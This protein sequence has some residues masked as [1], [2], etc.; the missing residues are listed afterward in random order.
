[1]IKLKNEGGN[2]LLESITEHPP[3]KKKIQRI[4]KEYKN[5][6]S[7]SEMISVRIPDFLNGM[8]KLTAEKIG[9]SYS[10]YIR[11]LLAQPFVIDVLEKTVSEE[12]FSDKE[13]TEAT[14][15]EEIKRL[16]RF[17]EG[18]DKINLAEKSI[19]KARNQYRKLLNDLH[20]EYK[21]IW[22]KPKN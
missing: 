20:E 19:K 21:K 13:Q 22:E 1:M 12:L 17:V 6:S 2:I 10:D 15:I 11:T 3:D 18:A 7:K 16:D 14:L 4:L 5:K 8:L 9:I